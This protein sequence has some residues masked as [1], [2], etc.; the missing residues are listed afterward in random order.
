M[1][2]R[3]GPAAPPPAPA[4]AVSEP[5]GITSASS[6]PGGGRSRRGDPAN[7]LGDGASGLD[8]RRLTLQEGTVSGR[9]CLTRPDT[10]ATRDSAVF[11]DLAWIKERGHAE[12]PVAFASPASGVACAE[13][14]VHRPR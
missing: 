2:A 11:D 14:I 4:G 3:E 10:A 7:R 6:T 1:T 5:R 12:E 13:K 9:Y 8:T